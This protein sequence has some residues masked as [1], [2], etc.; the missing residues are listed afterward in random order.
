MSTSEGAG[1]I[2]IACI[3]D[4]VTKGIG[5]G[6]PATESYP[7]QLVEYLHAKGHPAVDARNFGEGGAGILKRGYNPFW[8]T[9]QFGDALAFDPDVLV[10]HLGTNDSRQEFWGN[11]ASALLR[12]QEDI[13]SSF[14][15]EEALKAIVHG[16][17]EFEQDLEELVEIF[18]RMPAQPQIFLC[19][20]PPLFDSSGWL[21]P[22]IIR[23][24][25]AP[26]I[27]RI[28]ARKGLKVIELFDSALAQH[29]DF[30]PDG[31]HPNAAGAAEIAALIGFALMEE[32]GSNGVDLKYV[33]CG[34][35]QCNQ[36]VEQDEVA[37]CNEEQMMEKE[38]EI[39]LGEL[40]RMREGQ[41]LR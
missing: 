30:F 20:P 37:A 10:I 29:H 19:T 26:R 34:M 2:R 38:R 27:R 3:G 12:A 13:F 1:P 21:S 5:L 35:A 39:V 33:D 28:G 15:K 6:K 9:D 40:H 32:G 23:T 14:A 22:D 11:D 7:A 4:S 18:S 36:A 25:I 17:A 41:R 16:E 24:E 8:D 31:L